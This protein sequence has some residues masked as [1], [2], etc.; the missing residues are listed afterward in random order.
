MN[1][2]TRLGNSKLRLNSCYIGTENSLHVLME[3]ARKK[4]KY[5]NLDIIELTIKTE[6]VTRTVVSS[7]INQ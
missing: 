5:K 7:I 3:I 6:F 4:Y 1:L 2:S